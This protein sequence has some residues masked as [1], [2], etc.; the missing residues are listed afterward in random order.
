MDYTQSIGNVVELQCISK[1]IEMGF[2]CSIPYGNSAKY[3]F[4]ADLGNG[5]LIRVQCKSAINPKRDGVRDL[6]A[7]EINCTCSTTNTKKTTR[8]SYTEKEIDYFATYFN[9]QVYLIPVDE[10]STSKTLRFVPP[11]NNNVNY[12]KAEDYEIETVIGHLQN[13][14]F[15]NLKEQHFKEVFPKEPQYK[16]TYI[17]SQC[18]KNIVSRAGGICVE[19]ANI[20]S[21]I[22]E[23][24][25]RE[26]LKQMIRTETFVSI[27]Q[28]FGVSDNAIKKWCKAV[29][30][31]HRKADIKCI[32]DNKWE[33]I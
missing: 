25:T 16:E 8:H 5:E 1:F 32:P 4:I 9:Q 28:K 19:C 24:P 18:G 20:N 7:I 3:D 21:R 27:G 33:E 22:V 6:N 29:N 31:P 11:Q 26:E 30:L 2:Q 14:D 15:I 10:C 23:R 13:D 12:N 17:C